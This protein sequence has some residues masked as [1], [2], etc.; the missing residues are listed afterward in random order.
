MWLKVLLQDLNIPKDDEFV[1]CE[2]DQ[3]SETLE[4][5]KK[6]IQLKKKNQLAWSLL[7]I[8]IQD[9]STFGLMNSAKPEGYTEGHARSAWLAIETRFKPKSD[10][11]KY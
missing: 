1:D 5:D 9:K 8:C 7:T 6:A 10:A 3:L 2:V 11:N 4:A